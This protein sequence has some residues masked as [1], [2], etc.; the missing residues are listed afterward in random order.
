MPLNEAIPI[1]ADQVS[2]LVSTAARAPSVHNTQ[3]WRFQIN[4][5]DIELLAD[6]SRKLQTDPLGREM[7]L[8]CGAALFGLRLAVRSLGYQPVVEMLPVRS[9]LR[10][11]ARVALTEGT[12]MTALER[13]MLYAVP[14]RH[15]HRGSF[16]ASLLPPGLLAGMQHDAA[17]EGA[18]L[19]LVSRPIDYERLADLITATAPH[20][21]R[22]PASRSAVL[23]WSRSTGSADRDGV[24]ARA[25]PPNPA[26]Q[27]GHLRQRDFDLGRDIGVQP[28][29]GDPPSATAVLVTAGDRRLD[30][31][32]AGQALQ[33]L[34]LHGATRWVFA[35][36]YTQPLES[37]QIRNM[38][39]ER[40]ALPGFPQ[41]L[42][43]LG[44]VDRSEPTIRR[45]PEDVID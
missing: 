42:L 41:V 20:Q 5:Y 12:P 1:P 33:R 11:L 36:L 8:S 17:E 30:W 4:D 6:P 14:R 13:Q 25:F 28:T 2:Y 16:R 43:Q 9:R 29:D 40:L 39:K 7:L 34:L 18:T 26:S 31:L 10:L 32:K 22:D 45:P 27:P 35:S 44:V 24:P 23:R 3:P 37:A 15:T 19:A 38:I 21:D